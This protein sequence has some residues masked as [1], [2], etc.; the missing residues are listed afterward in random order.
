M[1]LK[2]A[3]RNSVLQTAR[4]CASPLRRIV[5]EK[6]FWVKVIAQIFQFAVSTAAEGNFVGSAGD[7]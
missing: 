6:W 2:A 4:I 1:L 5:N 3:Q 7:K